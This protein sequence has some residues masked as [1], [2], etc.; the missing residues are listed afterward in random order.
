MA[1]KRGNTQRSDATGRRLKRWLSSIALLVTLGLII[2]PVLLAVHDEAFQLDGNVIDTDVTNIDGQTQNVDWATL[3]N[4]DG[5]THTAALVP[6]GTPGFHHAKLDAD[7]GINTNGSFNTLD[8]TTYTTG[9]KDTLS[10]TPGWQCTI[11]NNVNSKVDL[12]NVYAADYTAPNG[13][14]FLYFG[15]ERNVNTGDANIGFWFLQGDAS[16]VSTGGTVAWTGHH[17][18]GDLLIVSAFTKGGTVPGI[19]AYAW[20]CPMLSGAAC[21]AQG[22]LN[23]TPVAN[24]GDCRDPLHPVNDSICAVSNTSPITTPWLTVKKTMVDNSLDTGE[25]FEGGINLTQT[26]FGDKCFNTFVGDTR[27]SQSPTATIFDYARGTLG[28]CASTT[29]TSASISGSASIGTGSISLVHDTANI[30]VDGIS[31][32]NGT[33]QFYLC[34]PS[35]G[36]ITVPCDDG[37]HGTAGVAIGSAQSVTVNGTKTSDNVTLT[38]VGNYCWGAVFSG[39]AVAG[40]PGSQDDGT[41]ECFSVSPVTPT[42]GTNAGAGPVNLGTAV[43]DT[44]GLSG[45]A[46]QPGSGGLGNGTINP[47]TPGSPAAGTI[48]FTLYGPG[49]CTTVA[50]GTGTNPQ[51]VNV[52]GDGTY[53]PVSFTPSTPGTYH[54][55]ASYSGNSPNTNATSHN[56]NCSDTLEDVVVSQIPTQIKTKQSWIPNDTATITSTNGNLA[57]GGTVTFDL[58]LT[59]VNCTGTAAYHEVKTL[60][61]GNTSEPVSTSNTTSFVINTG[62]T[63]NASSLAGP[64]SWKVVYAPAAADT[65]HKGTQSACDAEHF[66]ITYTND[67]GPNTSN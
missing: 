33:V 30:H 1:W 49:N 27:S 42:L 11:S 59:S 2:V 20:S 18:D 35:V 58:Y 23:L 48:T 32:F 64:Y 65:A 52:S 55:V 9:S 22:F 8:G 24:S 63:D 38:S 46:S 26:G 67:P 50:A 13:N 29:T 10:I 36:V 7:F 3:I 12:M 39:D 62:Y 44:A 28:E 47:T 40:V 60:V 14:R 56:T 57:A 16:C 53:G 51:T 31:T 41:S 43:T 25:F 21:D 5:S 34:G 61:G 45:T 19:T 17:S 66:G 37:T 6:S 54:W 15:L 4:P